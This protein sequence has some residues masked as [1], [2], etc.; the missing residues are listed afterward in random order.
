MAKS[1]FRLRKNL[2]EPVH[3]PV[4]PVGV[5]LTPLAS[6][7]PQALHAL[8]VTAYAN[9]F[10]EV[11]DYGAWWANLNA[12]EEFDPSL[13]LIATDAGMPVGLAQSWTSGFVKDLV[14]SP[15]HRGKGLGAALLWQTFALFKARGATQ[16]DLKVD[17]NNAD[18]QRLYVRV[19]MLEV[20]T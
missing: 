14:V 17:Q 6:A 19:G 4:W 9:G 2:D 13:V 7:D 11:A 10:G 15:G 16:V 20:T 5:H 8:L 12:D 1:F 18:A 3:A